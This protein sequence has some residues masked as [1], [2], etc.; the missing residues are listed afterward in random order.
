VLELVGGGRDQST[1][2]TDYMELNGGWKDS[3][4]WVQITQ[5][6]VWGTLGFRAKKKLLKDSSR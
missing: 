4:N 5:R 6:D 1:N 2:K 3:S